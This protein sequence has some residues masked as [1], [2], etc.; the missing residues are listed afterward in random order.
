MGEAE[1][2]QDNDLSVTLSFPASFTHL[3]VTLKQSEA[4]A[5]K[6]LKAKHN[7]V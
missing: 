2:T 7:S 3:G 4:L 6:P 1:D 5:S